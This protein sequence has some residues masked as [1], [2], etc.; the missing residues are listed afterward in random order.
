MAKKE[1]VITFKIDDNTLSGLD[2]L[3]KQIG[4]NR[5]ELLRRAAFYLVHDIK[6]LTY[7]CRNCGEPLVWKDDPFLANRP[8]VGKIT[9][10]GCGKENDLF[11]E[12]G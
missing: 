2:W 3:S 4:E 9:C 1:K 10:P 6:R 8:G 11:F 12:E 7:P 5:S